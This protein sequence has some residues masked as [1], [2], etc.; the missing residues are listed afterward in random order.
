[1]KNNFAVIFDMDGVLVDNNHVHIEAWKIF[2]DKLGFEL[3]P[4]K[5]KNDI[6][7][8]TNSDAFKRLYDPNLTNEE[9]KKLS[10]EKEALY[11]EIYRPQIKPV[12]GLIEFLN[13]LKR[14][15]IPMAIATSAI[16]ENVEFV[17]SELGISSY[18]KVVINE[19]HVT[20]GKPDPQVYLMAASQLGFEPADCIVIEDS[21]SGVQAGLN[22]GCKVIG[23]T[24]SH[25]SG[26]LA[27]TQLVSD[28]FSP[29]TFEKVSHLS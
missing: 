18:F 20:K 23:L 17:T 5:I 6:F 1:M 10:Q 24:T 4:E 3:T 11:R 21:L 13:E 25:S 22:A 16:E 8:R 7:G 19:S 29:L 26:E 27:S 15:S 28:D 9:L 12:K 2:A 14:H